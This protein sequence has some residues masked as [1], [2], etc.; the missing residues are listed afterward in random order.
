[1]PRRL[2]RQRLSDISLRR[3]HQLKGVEIPNSPFLKF[4]LVR[5]RLNELALARIEREARNA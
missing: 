1:M 2:G 3:L 5:F 4:F